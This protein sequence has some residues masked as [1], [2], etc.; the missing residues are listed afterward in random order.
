MKITAGRMLA[1]IFAVKKCLIL[2]KS[3]QIEINLTI[4]STVNVMF[5]G[6]GLW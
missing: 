2:E 4:H 1:V 5:A 6:T 3:L